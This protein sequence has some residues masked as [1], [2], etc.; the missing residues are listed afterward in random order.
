MRLHV[1]FHPTL[2][3]TGSQPPVPATRPQVCVVVDVIRASTTMVTFVERGASRIYIASGIAAARNWGRTVDGAV[4]AGEEDAVAPPGFDYGN[5]PV[6]ASEAKVDGRPV[7]FAT[8][9]GTAAIRAVYHLGPVL[10]GALRNA[11][12]VAGEAVAAARERGCDLTIVCAGREGGFG[13]D[14]AYCAGALVERV[15]Q[16]ER[17]ELTDAADAALRLRRSSPD[18]LELF[19][20]TAAGQ[21]VIRLGLGPDVD[22]CAQTDVSPA[23]PRLGRELE[24]LEDGRADR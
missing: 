9:N 23:V 10:V 24:M 5:S 6:E 22:F 1:A 20:Q 4:M 8:T 17:M 13:L 18:A 15:L 7:V 2:L 14:D 11:R 3:A 19:K 16:V 12:A 21:N